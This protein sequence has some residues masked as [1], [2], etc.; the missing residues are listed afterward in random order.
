MGRGALAQHDAGDA[1]GLRRWRDAL[2]LMRPK[3]TLVLPPARSENIDVVMGAPE[4]KLYEAVLAMA[5]DAFAAAS[6][7]FAACAAAFSSA[8]AKSADC[9]A[10]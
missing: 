10:A 6:A 8:A 4:R 2:L 1:V 7:S 5:R 3:S 9:S